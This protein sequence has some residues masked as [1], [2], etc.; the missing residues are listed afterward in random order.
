M[1]VV[2]HIPFYNQDPNKKEGF[3]QLTRFDYLLDNLRSTLGISKIKYSKK[4][5]KNI[6]FNV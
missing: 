4:K 3:R 6:Q 1:S 2:I 5:K